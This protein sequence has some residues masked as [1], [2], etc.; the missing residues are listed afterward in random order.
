MINSLK[1]SAQR[2]CKAEMAAILK[3]VNDLFEGVAERRIGASKIKRKKLMSATAAQSTWLDSFG[4]KWIATNCAEGSFD[5]FDLFPAVLA[6][7]TE[8]RFANDVLTQPTATGE[9]NTQEGINERRDGFRYFL[10]AS[11][12]T[13]RGE[14]QAL[15][16]LKKTLFLQF[17]ASN[18]MSR[19][20][21]SF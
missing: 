20:R 7:H 16:F 15:L 4:N 18:A 5:G 17:L 9:D 3:L 2:A 21:N 14:S 19:P 8:G 11:V 10:Q 12:P 1:I 6:N 13:G